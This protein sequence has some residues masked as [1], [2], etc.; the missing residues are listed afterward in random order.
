M[1]QAPNKRKREKEKE[2]E[3]V[4][5]PFLGTFFAQRQAVASAMSISIKPSPARKTR[6]TDWHM[7]EGK[8]QCQRNVRNSN[9]PAL[10]ALQRSKHSKPS[11]LHCISHQHI[12]NHNGM[13]VAEPPFYRVATR[14][15]RNGT[16]EESFHE[17]QDLYHQ[18]P[19][20]TQGPETRQIR[21]R[22][23][24]FFKNQEPRG[25]LGSNLL[26]DSPTWDTVLKAQ[27][28]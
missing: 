16:G 2:R 14:D 24:E 26:S 7:R 4:M 27:H 9:N 3:R 1:R 22:L 25:R 21:R 18:A 23:E 5:Q 10:A 13:V 28:G 8:T 19:C 17:R 11:G 6:Q 15:E 20:N 12:G